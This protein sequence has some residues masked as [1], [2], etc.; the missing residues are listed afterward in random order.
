MAIARRSSRLSRPTPPESKAASTTWA[1]SPIRFSIRLRTEFHAVAAKLAGARTFVIL[2]PVTGLINR[3]ETER[4]L[5]E[6]ACS[7]AETSAAVRR[8]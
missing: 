6:A 2:D 1:A 4:K 5:M 8:G 3:R 7:A